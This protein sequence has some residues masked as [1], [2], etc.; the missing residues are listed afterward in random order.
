MSIVSVE[1]K[2][3]ILSR[4]GCVNQKK[5][6]PCFNNVLNLKTTKPGFFC[7]RSFLISTFLPLFLV[8]AYHSYDLSSSEWAPISQTHR[9]LSFIIGQ[10][11]MCFASFGD[12]PYRRRSVSPSGA[13][14]GRFCLRVIPP[15]MCTNLPSKLYVETRTFSV[16]PKRDIYDWK[17]IHKSRFVGFWHAWE[18]GKKKKQF[19]MINCVGI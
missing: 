17:I 13:V 10:G 2:R 16:L 11:R 7:Q 12:S 6:L 1:Q 4:G 18:E 8:L 9:S 19:V 5:V 3:S 15:K 14:Q